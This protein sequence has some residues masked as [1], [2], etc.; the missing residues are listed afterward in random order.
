MEVK[1]QDYSIDSIKN[2]RTVWFDEEKNYV[3]MI[4]QPLLPHKFEVIDLKHY[5]DTASSIK[6]MTVRGAGA[7]GATAAYGLAQATNSFNMTCEDEL[8][9]FIQHIDAVYDCFKETR[10]T[11]VDLVNGMDYVKKEILKG[12]S[13][14]ECKKLAIGAAQR[15]ADE[16]NRECEMIGECGE[17]LIEDDF[18]V[19]THCNAGKLAF[20]NWGSATAPMYKAKRNGKN[21]FVFVDETRPRLQGARLTAWELSQ[22]GIDHAVIPDNAA[23]YFMKRGE[24]DLVIV[25]SDR[26]VGKTGDVANKIGTYEKAVLAKENGIPFY[27]AIPMSTLDWNLNSG[28]EIPIEERNQNEVLYAWGIDEKGEKKRVRVANAN[29]PA[30]NP[31]FDVTPAKYITGI[32]T[33]RGIFKPNELGKLRD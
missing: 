20:V 2:H 10:P 21:I 28:D 24:V 26:V 11:A 19:L 16:Q 23:G 7:I 29:S 4:N 6:N 5:T 30:R 32:I 27:V 8:E 18:K 12:D 25:G 22:E 13:F 17:K 33:P 3:K 31:A 14:S 1:I 15:F 9:D